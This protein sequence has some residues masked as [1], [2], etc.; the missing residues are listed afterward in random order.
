MFPVIRL[1]RFSSKEGL[2]HGQRSGQGVSQAGGELKYHWVHFQFI[3]L[4]RLCLS[5]I[6]QVTVNAQTVHVSYWN[7]LF[8]FADQALGMAE[9][10][11]SANYEGLTTIFN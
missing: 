4:R 8:R 2:R 6:V 3:C 7:E 11:P 1:K 9:Q 10:S 5:K